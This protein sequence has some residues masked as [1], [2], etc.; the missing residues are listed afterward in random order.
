MTLSFGVLY[1]VEFLEIWVF[2][3]PS[4]DSSMRFCALLQVER[5][6]SS[7]SLSVLMYSEVT[8]MFGALLQVQC[9]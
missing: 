3:S 2:V 1:Q 6:W 9:L 8:L 4:A 7:E 5:L